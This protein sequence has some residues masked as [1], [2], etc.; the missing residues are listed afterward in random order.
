MSQETIITINHV[1]KHYD[2]GDNTVAALNGVDLKIYA[3]D[4]A[5]IYGP[6]GCGK[7]TLLNVISGLEEPT[8]GTVSIR[9]EKIYDLN[10]DE[11]AK[12]RSDKFGIIT[13]TSNW[14]KSLNVWENVAIPLVLKGSSF[15]EAKQRSLDVLKEVGME[16]YAKI[17]PAKL[18]GGQQQ[19]V[20]IA[21]ALIRNPWIIIAD[22]PTGNLDTHSA[23]LIMSTFKTLNS[24]SKRTIIM[25]THNLIYLPYATQQVGM[26]DGK[27]VT[28]SRAEIVKEIEAEVKVLKEAK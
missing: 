7:S 18:S 2:V 9:G 16:E 6:S 28:N 11:R 1:V 24:K 8:S 20:S 23:D 10:E 22:E 25:V 5:I 19:R 3:K 21:R 26:K 14:I 27:V 15:R 17:I 13:Q 12:F 4:F